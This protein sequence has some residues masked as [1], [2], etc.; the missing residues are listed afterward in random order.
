MKKG[1]TLKLI[2][3]TLSL[4]SVLCFA[5]GCGGTPHTHVF[6]Q[7]VV[8]S[9]YLES[10]ATCEAKAKYYYSCTCGEKSEESFE[11]GEVLGHDYGEWIS[12]NDGTHS[13]ICVNDSA[14][15]VTENCS[16]GTAT[17]A[18]LAICDICNTKYGQFAQ[19]DYTNYQYNN[20]AKC[21]VD[22]TETATCNY[23][24]GITDTR[25]KV[26]SAM[27]H[28]YGKG[29]SNNDG[30]H[31]KICEID[32]SHKVTE[33]CTFVDY[34]CSS[35]GY[36]YY[37]EG[38]VFTLSADEKEYSVTDYTGSSTSVII[39]STYKGKPVTSIT[40]RAFYNHTALTSV[41]IGNSVTSIGDH[42]FNSCTSL[43]NIV[44]PNSVASIGVN[45]FYGCTKLQYNI[46]NELKYLGNNINK[47]LYLVGT[48]TNNLTTVAI[49][50]NCKFI[51]TSAFYSYTSLTSLTVPN[52]VISI[53]FS[54]FNGCSN[55]TSV[56]I[57]DGLT[58]IGGS[59]FANCTALTSIT[60]PESVI[61]IVEEAFNGC[62]KLKSITIPDNVTGIGPKVFYD[63]T[64]LTSVNIP[65]SVALIGEKVFN[66]CI[67]LTSITVGDN[68]QNYKSIDGDLY[69]KNGKTLLQ[70]AIGKTANSYTIPNSVTSIGAYAFAGSASLVSIVIPSNVINISEDALRD[71]KK[72][73]TVVIENGTMS[74][75][76]RAFYNC[77]ALTDITI[78][79]SVTS[80]GY[81]AFMGCSKLKY[82][83]EGNL[84]YLGNDTNK[85]LYLVATTSTT[86]K[87]VTINANC[88]F[89]GSRAFYKCT[90]LTSIEIPN[91]VTS[92][93]YNAFYGCSKLTSVTI[94]NSV[95]SIGSSAFS[96]CS[97]LTSVVIGDSVRSIGD[98]AFYDCSSLTSIKFDGTKAEWNAIE[99]GDWNSNVPA[100]DIVCSNGVVAIS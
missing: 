75:G 55:L 81:Y 22:G 83:I 66:G 96:N 88:K 27:D 40:Y 36:S 48:T 14:H 46:E 38:L 35:C 12:N 86:L 69:T 87:T 44:I 82:N 18:E 20:D 45:A 29:V 67:S 24:C 31:T 47:Y 7:E 94:P 61:T 76:V 41:T 9:E 16:G 97:K 6:E 90:L 92:I 39:P 4:A 10:E 32:A 33:E 64:S 11:Y 100:T 53:D 71:C 51:G 50:N 37:T 56:T 77:S 73:T 70:Y 42:A 8:S 62:V 79:D 43:T 95:T 1:L 21:E 34:N 2:I 98:Y 25:T 60:I 59:A 89:I 3:A 91:S 17:C 78:P 63:C 80:I 54:A 19:H 85:Y 49:N 72:L 99:K 93:E 26:G 68:N 28:T 23:G 30:T 52:S 57:G 15:K 74:I 65:N 58:R 84:K 5:I 13:K